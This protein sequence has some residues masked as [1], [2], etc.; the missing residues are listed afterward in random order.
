MLS[1]AAFPQQSITVASDITFAEIHELFG[2]DKQLTDLQKKDRWK[3]YDG[4]CVE[5]TGTLVHLDT[6]LFGGLNIGMKHLEQTFTY[7]V[8]ISAPTSE[9]DRFMSWTVGQRY[10]YRVTL[11]RYGGVIMPITA[12]WGC[13]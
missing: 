12:D 7:D 3:K 9:K 1:T 13:E 6:G 11:D 5:W 2:S 10:T 8:L 4:Q